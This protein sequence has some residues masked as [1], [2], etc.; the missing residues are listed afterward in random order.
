MESA[1]LLKGGELPEAGLMIPTIKWW[2]FFMTEAAQKFLVIS[3]GAAL[4]AN[5]RYWVGH[6]TPRFFGN[7]FPYATALVNL[8]GCFAIGLI[9]TLS[10]QRITM[11]PLTRLFVFV[12]ILGGYTTFS[13]FGWE[14]YEMFAD[15][16]RLN[17]LRD[18]VLQV[19]GG[20]AAVW[21]GASLAGIL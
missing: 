10:L 9:M 3:L 14:T 5:S 18:A 1:G 15:G 2:G 6:F 17:A 11:T 13:A 7:T 20:L 16:Y 4:G 21:A 8:T 12:G 19:G